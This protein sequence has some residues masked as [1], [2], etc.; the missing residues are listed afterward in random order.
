MY[1]EIVKQLIRSIKE[2]T[3][4]PGSR[5][6]SE[7][8]LSKAFGVSRNCIRE[9]LKS[10][11]LWGIISAKAGQGTFVTPDALLKIE[12]N[13]LIDAISKNASMSE[14]METR[15]ILETELARLAALRATKQD[16]KEL[17]TTFELL[18]N[19]LL[20]NESDKVAENPTGYGLD[21]HMCIARISKNNLLTKFM[22][23]IRGELSEERSRVQLR[24]SQDIKTM[25]RDHEEICRAVLEGD[26]DGAAD[27]MK[28]H[29]V[30]SFKNMTGGKPLSR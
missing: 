1:E 15:L 30:N 3:W 16:K 10:L 2:D 11:A 19:Q 4:A 13:E 8:E 21:F 5:L 9:A 6:P 27:A 29:L 18:K 14:L 17:L 23:S 12:N 7:M 22:Q 20:K 26:A 24:T 25:L 28:R